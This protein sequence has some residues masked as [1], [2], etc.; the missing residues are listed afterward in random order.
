[1]DHDAAVGRDFSTAMLTFGKCGRFASVWAA[2]D[3]WVW[4]DRAG[5]EL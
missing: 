4:F 1:M 2:R 5:Q 3:Q